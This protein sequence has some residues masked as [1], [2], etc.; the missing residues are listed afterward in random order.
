MPISTENPVSTAGVNQS[1][2]PTT[3]RAGG[4]FGERR[5]SI[6]GMRP[7]ASLILSKPL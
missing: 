4:T 7:I 3:A 2:P 1:Q 6:A 5:V